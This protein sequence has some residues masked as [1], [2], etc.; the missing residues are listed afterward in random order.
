[1]TKP[2]QTLDEAGAR[3]SIVSPKDGRVRAWN[4]TEW[5]DEFLVDVPRAQARPADSDAIP[6]PGGV[7]NPDALQ[8]NEG[9]VLFAQRFLD[10]GKP[11]ATICH[12]PWTPIETGKG[13]GRR[14]A[15]WPSLQ[16]DLGN[17]GAEWVDQEPVVDG[18]LVSSS[19]PDEIPACSRVMIRL[20]SHAYAGQAG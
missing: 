16:T 6:L 13:R 19:K 7:I 5:G 1:M 14:F 17:T 8:V 18:D 2:R 4:F 12:G 9:A 3:T 15:S 11:V 10:G 20:F